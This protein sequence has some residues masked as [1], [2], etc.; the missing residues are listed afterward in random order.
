MRTL[1]PSQLNGL[2]AAKKRIEILDPLPEES[3]RIQH[4]PNARNLCVYEIDFLAKAKDAYP[5]KQTPIIV[6]G[7]DA[8]FQAAPLAARL[9]EKAGYP[10]IAIL[11]GGLD[12]WIND[13]FA[14]EGDGEPE[15]PPH[16]D[17][18][19]DTERSV[20][21]WIGRNL[22][23]QHHGVVALKQ[24][25]FRFDYGA[26]VS[27]QAIIDLTK[28]ECHDIEDSSMRKTLINHLRSTDFFSVDSHPEARFEIVSAERIS[29]APAGSPN[30]EITGSLTLRGHT[31]GV[32]FEASVGQQANDIGIQAHFDLDRVTWGSRYGSGKLFEA[33]GK[34][35][36]NDALSISFQLIAPR[37]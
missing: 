6:Y 37:A 36:V 34:H 9:L 20:V 24:A 27:G 31:D 22:L 29:G 26:L 13:G 18:T 17:F 30:Y 10:N 8:R 1:E 15:K 3:Y 23:N 16:G 25:S 32:L 5:D 14:L 28:I 11:K 7:A 19:A 12:A 2:I 21:R 35:L 4:L 33:I